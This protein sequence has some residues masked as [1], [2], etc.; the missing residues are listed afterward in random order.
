M[1][2]EANNK[3]LTA[4]KFAQAAGIPYSTLIDWLEA[5][6]VPGASLVEFAG[7]SVWQIPADSINKIQR[8]KMGR[9][10]S[11]KGK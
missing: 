8:P 10:K 4:K 1:K 6:L 9:P 3:M 11:K 7:V 5:G 2:K